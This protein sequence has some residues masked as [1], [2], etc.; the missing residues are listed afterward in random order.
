MERE[1]FVEKDL[2]R[3]ACGDV[4]GKCPA[5]CDADEDKDC[6]FEEEEFWCDVEPDRFDD[7]CVSFVDTEDDCLFC[8][9]GYEDDRGNPPE[10]CEDLCGDDTDD[11]CP[12]P[13]SVFF[14]QDCCYEE[15]EDNFWCDDV[16]RAGLGSVCEAAISSSECNDCPKGYRDEGRSR[17]DTCS[18]DDE[19]DEEIEEFLD[20]DYNVELRVRF[21]ETNDRKR[22]VVSV[23]GFDIS[24]DTRNLE[25]TRNIDSFV[26]SGSNTLEIIPET[27]FTITEIEV[28]LDFD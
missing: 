1:F 14:D 20:V 15:D 6:C 26:R 18:R 17:P 23:N 28:E 16:P 11:E 9:S 2:I 7:R 5:G 27:D 21:G 8:E 13:C 3:T 24:F 22:F 25:A 4:D 12:S 19:E 10:P